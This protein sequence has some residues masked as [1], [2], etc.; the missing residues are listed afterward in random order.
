MLS[1]T[2]ISKCAQRMK[3]SLF[4]MHH[5]L[6][7]SFCW[8]SISFEKGPGTFRTCHALV[9]S[10]YC[11]SVSCEQGTGDL[12]NRVQARDVSR[13]GKPGFIAGLTRKEA[14]GSRATRWAVPCLRAGSEPPRER[15]VPSSRRGGTALASEATAPAGRPRLGAFCPR[16]RMRSRAP[17]AA[18]QKPAL[19]QKGVKARWLCEAS[20]VMT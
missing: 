20:T 16:A 13:G 8:V 15:H 18:Y 6:I 17:S 12:H 10:V 2:F 7:T 11:A 9:T 5:A 14:A 3:S 19:F 4:R 1:H